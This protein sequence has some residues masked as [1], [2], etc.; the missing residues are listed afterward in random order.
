MLVKADSSYAMS[1]REIDSKRVDGKFVDAE[2]NKVSFLILARSSK[3]SHDRRK[4]NTRSSS[5]YVAAMV[6][7]I[8]SCLNPSQSLKSSCQS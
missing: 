2:G 4:D 5:S 7:S 8:D 6:S 1:L 3:S